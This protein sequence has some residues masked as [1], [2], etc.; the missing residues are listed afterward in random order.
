MPLGPSAASSM[1]AIMQL[2][3]NAP[4]DIINATVGPA[5]LAEISN[6]AWADA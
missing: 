6:N 1:A 3:R 5:A 2:V 4:D